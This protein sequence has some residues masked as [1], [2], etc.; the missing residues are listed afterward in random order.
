MSI[1][2]ERRIQER[3]SVPPKSRVKLNATRQCPG[4]ARGCLPGSPTDPGEQIFRTWFWYTDQARILPCFLDTG[5]YEGF[6]T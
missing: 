4:R 5:S 2:S 1:L 6:F 3:T